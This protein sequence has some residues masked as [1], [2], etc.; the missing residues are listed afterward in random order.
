MSERGGGAWGGVEGG[1]NRQNTDGQNTNK[2]RKEYSLFTP[3]FR[4]AFESFVY[5]SKVFDLAY[6]KAYQCLKFDHMP[7]FLISDS[8]MKLEQGTQIR[9]GS[10]SKVIELRSIM[11]EPR[12][13]KALAEF[14]KERNSTQQ[15]MFMKIWEVSEKVKL[16]IDF[17]QKTHRIQYSPPPFHNRTSTTSNSTTTSRK[18]KGKTNERRTSGNPA[19]NR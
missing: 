15:L 19:K 12:A 3:P 2:I 4:L 10:S 16:N 5:D 13:N 1:Q 18:P 11:S 8:F 14:L 9:R 7:Q 6:E 17:E